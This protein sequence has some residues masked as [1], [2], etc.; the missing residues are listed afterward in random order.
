MKRIAIL[1][2]RGGSK[3]LPRK[4]ILPVAGRPM[5]SH[6]VE[7]VRSCGL[8]SRILVSS[9][10]GEILRIAEQAGAEAVERDPALADD[11]TGVVEVCRDLLDRLRHQGQLP[12][13]F[14]CVYAT[15]IFLD[16]QDFVAS[17][18]L[19]HETPAPD[20]VMGVSAFPLHP[21]KAL[22]RDGAYLRPVFPEWVLR[23]STEYPHHVA[24]NGTFYWAR[25]ETFL[26]RPS[27]YVERL[28]GHEIPFHRAID[29]DT[30]EDYEL[31]CRLAAGGFRP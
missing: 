17:E 10:D 11:R 1:P 9:D 16:A 6:T 19:F 27:F 25:S 22:E 26:K 21:Y 23:K 5:L 13:L 8:F 14:C 20:V 2:A 12:D 31:A 18:R 29:I 30:R 15:A 7:R 3:R 24:S 28:A 4:N